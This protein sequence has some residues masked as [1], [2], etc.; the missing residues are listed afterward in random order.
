MPAQ[1]S[2]HILMIKPAAFSFN[3]QTAVNNVFQQ[4]NTQEIQQQAL[5][6]FEAMVALLK[7]NNIQVTVLED[8]ALPHTPDSIFPNNW[9]STHEDGRLILYPMFAKN[10]RTERI[11]HHDFLKEHFIINSE[12]DFSPFETREMYL[13]GTGSLVLDRQNKIAYACISPRTNEILIHQF[14]KEMDYTPVLFHAQSDDGTLLYHTNVM[15]CVGH[16][17]VVVCL[18]AVKD[19]EEKELLVNSIKKT[20]RQLVEINMQQLHAFAG[21]MLEVRNK[22]DEPVIIMSEN[23]YKSLAKEQIKTLSTFAKIIYT[24]LYSIEAAGGGSAR[25]MLAE[26]FLPDKKNPVNELTGPQIQFNR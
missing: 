12:T 17:F 16:S 7:E 22:K 2:N 10:R 20:G 11:K 4:P 25:C 18:A 14:C 15:M 21:N 3:E 9:F 24:P 1:L 19:P 26:I 8:S 6:E 13:E 23:A 5:A